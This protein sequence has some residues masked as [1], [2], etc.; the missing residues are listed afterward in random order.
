LR[1]VVGSQGDV[2]SRR[3]RTATLRRKT[4]VSFTS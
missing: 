4:A 1:R 2:S 3:S